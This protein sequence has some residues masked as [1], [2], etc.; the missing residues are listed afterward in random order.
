MNK[1]FKT[2][3]NEARRSYIVTNE[4]QK[5][6]GKPSKSAVALAVA[7]TAVL[8]MGAA[9]AAYVEPGFASTH[10]SNVDQAVA[11]WETDEYKADW[12]LEAIHASSAYALGYDGSGVT[13][14]VMDSGAFMQ[15]HPELSGD[16]F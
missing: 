11:S 7:A 1:T 9:N 13:V 15:H 4:A 8:T 10:V 16:R 6:H 2:I 5:T 3:W 12:G 14:G